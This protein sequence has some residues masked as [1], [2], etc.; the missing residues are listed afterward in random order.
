MTLPVLKFLGAD[1]DHVGSCES[2][3]AAALVCSEGF[4]TEQSNSQTP[5]KYLLD[6]ASRENKC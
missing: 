5:G 6:D 1:V 2:H 3:P 4:Q